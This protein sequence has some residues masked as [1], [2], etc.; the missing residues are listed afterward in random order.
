MKVRIFEETS[1]V[2]YGRRSAD[3]Q[4]RC[5][6]GEGLHAGDWESCMTWACGHLGFSHPRQE[7]GCKHQGLPHIE[8][9]ELVGLVRVADR[10]GIEVQP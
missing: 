6:C 7:P 3:W 9:S 2:H 10:L 4:A 5:E 8:W 1:H